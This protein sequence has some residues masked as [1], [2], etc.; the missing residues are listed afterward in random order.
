[1]TYSL[2]I[3]VVKRVGPQVHS[4]ILRNCSQCIL[5]FR[6]SLSEKNDT[7]EAGLGENADADADDYGGCGCGREDKMR[8]KG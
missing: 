6:C 5:K 2:F 1:M 7:I 8:T 3:R 4:L